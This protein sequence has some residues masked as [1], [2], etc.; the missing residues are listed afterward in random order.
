M[1][2]EADGQ[3][4]QWRVI[5]VDGMASREGA[6]AT[7]MEPCMQP[8]TQRILDRGAGLLSKGGPTVWTV[9]AS[10]TGGGPDLAE[11]RPG[12]RRFLLHSGKLSVLIVLLPV[13]RE[14]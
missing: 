4:S 5:P 3:D 8:C 14:R 1:G 11:I 7:V 13:R 9:E 12:R 10:S 2:R 6:A